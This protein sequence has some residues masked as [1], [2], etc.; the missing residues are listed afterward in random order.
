MCVLLFSSVTVF[1]SWPNVQRLFCFLWT[2][3]VLIN[4]SYCCEHQ[5]FLLCRTSTVLIAVNINCSYYVELQLFLLLWTSTVLIHR[6]STALSRTSS[7]LIVSNVN[8][9]YCC[10]HQL[11]LLCRI[12]TV[13][14]ASNI[15]C[16][17]HGEFNCSY[18]RRCILYQEST[19]LCQL[20]T[21]H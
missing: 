18:L 11:F 6:T 8:S 12:S 3:G 4:C 5:L 20:W 17:Y 15:N 21:Q 10:E 16:S 1:L 13:P 14:I 19:L 9:S 2:W 7:V